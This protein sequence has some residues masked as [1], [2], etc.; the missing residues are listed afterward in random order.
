MVFLC[1]RDVTSVLVSKLS[2]M[3]LW[4]PFNR[5]LHMPRATFGPISGSDPSIVIFNMFKL[6]TV[7]NC[8]LLESIKEMSSVVEELLESEL[9]GP[10]STVRIVLHHNRLIFGVIY[11]DIVEYKTAQ[12]VN[13]LERG[14]GCRRKILRGLW[15][16]VHQ[17][18]G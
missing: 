17:I 6:K 12:V 16:P 10:W 18:G 11:N 3:K 14:L 13:G 1:I 15:H 9:S 8:K 5:D 2:I 7:H 4:A